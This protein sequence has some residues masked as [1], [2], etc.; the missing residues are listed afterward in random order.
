[1]YD[2]S[3]NERIKATIDRWQPK[4]DELGIKLTE[5]DAREILESLRG[6]AE[7]LFEWDIQQKKK[8]SRV[9][10]MMNQSQSGNGKEEKTLVTVGELAKILDVPKSWIYSRTQLGPEAIPH[11]KVGKYLRFNPQDV[12]EFFKTKSRS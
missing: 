1:M 11:I 3:Y 5:E 6:F 7:L 10:S 2:N 12:I 8:I 9:T 4:Y